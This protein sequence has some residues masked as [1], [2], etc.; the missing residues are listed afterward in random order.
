MKLNTLHEDY[1]AAC[2]G[3][4][5]EQGGRGHNIGC[6]MGAANTPIAGKEGI[7]RVKATDPDVAP[8]KEL[9]NDSSY[10]DSGYGAP[11]GGRVFRLEFEA[12]NPGQI[13]SIPMPAGRNHITIESRYGYVDAWLNDEN[14]IWPEYRFA[15]HTPNQAFN[16]AD[17]AKR[18][19]K[20][21][22][23]KI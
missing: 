17:A 20:I 18:D 6:P 19:A 21:D 3:W 11:Q 23:L 10:A 22:E 15:K 2:G 13:G 4:D 7:L 16:P 8:W 12:L 1:C 5:K 9:S 14:Q